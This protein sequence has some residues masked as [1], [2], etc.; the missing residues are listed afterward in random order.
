[1]TPRR[2]H[3]PSAKPQ[4]VPEWAHG[5]A[6]RCPV[7]LVGEDLVLTLRPVSASDLDAG[8]R[9]S[10]RHCFARTHNETGSPA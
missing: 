4:P 9:W 7:L 10:A 2:T 5:A 8:A 6:W 1:M 3:E